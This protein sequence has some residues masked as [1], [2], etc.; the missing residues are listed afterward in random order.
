M[1]SMYKEVRFS[2]KLGNTSTPSFKTSVGVKQGCVLSPTLFSIY[3]N[4]MVNIFN[5][6]DCHPV[7]VNDQNVSCLL[8]AD[9]LVI[10]SQS[11]SGLQLLLLCC[12]S[13]Q[14]TVGILLTALSLAEAIPPSVHAL[15]LSIQPVFLLPGL[16]F[17][18]TSPSIVA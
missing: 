18:S 14:R 5:D 9:D 12:H 13:P 16:A 3:I 2:V 10:V 8:Y 17:P 6:P 4:D 7:C 1:E 11:E 15:M